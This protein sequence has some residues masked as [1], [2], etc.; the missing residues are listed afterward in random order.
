MTK[1]KETKEEK[2]EKHSRV[3]VGIIYGLLGGS[4]FAA[5][6]AVSLKDTTFGL[7][8]LLLHSSWCS[9]GCKRARGSDR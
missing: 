1:K 2:H 3:G 4:A 6:S 9:A 7:W 8:Y 5:V